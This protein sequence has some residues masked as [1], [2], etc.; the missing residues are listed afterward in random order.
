MSLDQLV[1]VNIST[2]TASVARASFGVPCLAAFHTN[3]VGDRVETYGTTQEMLDDGFLLT[4]PAVLW[5]LA[6]QAQNPKV[7]LWKIG[8]RDLAHTQEKRFTPSSVAA[9]L[10]YTIEV[11]SHDGTITS[12]SYEVQGGDAVLD[13]TAALQTS[14]DAITGITATDN[15]T[16]VEVVVDTPGEIFGYTGLNRELAMLGINADPGIAADLAAIIADDPSWYGLN[17]DSK[18]QAEINGAAA[19]IESEIRLFIA[20]TSDSG[21]KDAGD[22]TDIMSDLKAAAY[23]RTASIYH[24]D[25]RAFADGAWMGLQFPKTPGSST[26]AYQTLAGITV[27]PLKTSDEVAIDGKFGNRYTVIL[28]NNVTFEGKVAANDFIDIVRF[29]DSLRAGLQEDSFALLLNNE[30]IPFTDPGAATIQAAVEGR[31]GLAVESGG[32]AADPAPV[33]TVPLVASVSVANRVARTF[34]DV[35]FTATLAG[36]IHKLIINGVITV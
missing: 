34:P 35:N 2:L 6:L 10:V 16:D 36:A 21:C 3:T 25:D 12:V 18:S 7:P 22:S 28:D 5:A 29:V 30:K 17:L 13:I 19:F 20:Q 26:W 8:R 9:G 31:L 27:S 11:E 1:Q 14:L 32:L 4:D 23:A 24:E 33:V 15:A